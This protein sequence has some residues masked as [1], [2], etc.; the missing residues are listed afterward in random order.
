[1]NGNINALQN[2]LLL[3]LQD[4]KLQKKKE[5]KKRGIKQ[6]VHPQHKATV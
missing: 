3:F 5:K 6:S 2:V 1:M 4:S